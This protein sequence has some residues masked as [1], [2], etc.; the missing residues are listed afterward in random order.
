MRCILIAILFFP[1]WGFSQTDPFRN[2]ILSPSEMQ[3]D[4]S[5]LRKVFEQTHPGL[6]RY[7]SKNVMQAKLDSLEKLLVSE[8][9]FYDFYRILS[10]LISDI[11]CAHTHLLPTKDFASFYNNQIKTFP[12]MLF[13][14]EGSYYV[15]VNGTAETSIKPGFELLS[16]NGKSMH[17]IRNEMQRGLWSDGYNQTGKNKVLSEGFFPLFYYL[18]IEQSER[19]ILKMKDL[20]NVEIERSIPAQ[21]LAETKRFFKSNP[22]NKEILAIYD[23]KNK[24]ENKKGWRL[25]ITQ[26]D[27]IGI[28]RINAFGGG[29][30][31]EEARQKI[32]SFMD[33]CIKKL[34]KQKVTDLILDLRNNGGGWDIQ[35]I[36]LF[37]YFMDKPTRCYKRLHCL[38][39]ST[40][41]FSLSD[42]SAEDLSNVKKELRK[43]TDGTFS[44]M[45]EFSEQLQI[46]QPK[47]NRFTGKVYV[48]ANGGSAS[49]CAEFIAYA[50]SNRAL[51]VIGEESGGVYEGGNGGSFLNFEL[52]KSKIKVGSPLLYYDNDV[53]VP[54]LSGRGVLPDYPVDQKMRDLLKGVDTQF[55][56]AIELVRKI[57]K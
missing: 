5:Y 1:L 37:T 45:E 38:T 24:L 23:P 39:D 11:R 35:G 25:E 44:V 34:D 43:E 29:R 50:R 56:Y 30:N 51:T 48:L 57:R 22:V 3:E 55:N 27:N 28:I 21:Y 47:K 52:P 2:K 32:R 10:G 18:L 54:E 41:F 33:D 19:F 40:E 31:E 9:S 7:T 8:Q 15:T 46:Q 42:L 36:E 6:Y 13:F 20:N 26:K 12:L 53:S 16:I 17:S 49:A 4:F 14:T